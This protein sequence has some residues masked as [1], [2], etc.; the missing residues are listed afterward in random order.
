[1]KSKLAIIIISLLIG[2]AGGYTWR[3]KQI[4]PYLIG[5]IQELRYR[6]KQLARDLTILEV[7]LAIVEDRVKGKRR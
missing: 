4:E 6:Q 1:M 7:K 5:R 3:M 2:C